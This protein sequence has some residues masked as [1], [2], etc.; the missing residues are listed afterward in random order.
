MDERKHIIEAQRQLDGGHQRLN[1]SLCISCIFVIFFPEYCRSHAITAGGIEGVLLFHY[2]WNGGRTEAVCAGGK[3]V[4][5][6]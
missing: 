2:S 4:R 1:V 5:M 6:R 3:G